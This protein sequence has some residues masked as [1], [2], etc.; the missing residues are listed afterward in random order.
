MKPI[1]EH[2]LFI[3]LIQVFFLLV[4][5]RTLG[6]IFRNFRQPPVIG[7]LLA[8]ILLGPTVLGNISPDIFLWL[9]PSATPQPQMLEIIAWLG[10]LLLLL[11]AGMEIDISVVRRQGRLAI[12]TSIM[13]IIV[14]FISGVILG[15][16]IP[17]SYLIDPDQRLLFSLFLGT[18]MSISA[19]PVIARI[20]MDLDLIKT[21]LGM[22][23]I[24]AALSNDLVGWIIFSIVLG[25]M[26]G[27]GASLTGLAEIAS[28]TLGFALFCF[29]LGR[30][31]IDK[32]LNWAQ[33]I[34]PWPTGVLTLALGVTLL[35]SAITQWIG[36][37]AIFGAFLAGV[38]IGD[39]PHLR[40]RTRET[41]SEFTA[42]VFAPIFFATV[43]LKVNLLQSFN[44]V[45]VLVLFAVAC[46]GKLVGCNLGARWGG[47]AKEDALC[48]SIAMNVRGAM[49]IILAI[50]AFK[51]GLIGD[52]IFVA[53]L[54]IAVIT[55]L[56]AAPLMK[57]SM[58]KRIIPDILSFFPSNSILHELRATNRDGTIQELID[59][60]MDGS[61]LA[62]TKEEVIKAVIQRE[63][64]MGTG[65]GRGVAFPHARL[66]GL[67][68]PLLAF[69][70]SR[71]GVDFNA[72]DG[73]LVHLIFLILT[74]TEDKGVQLKTLP[75]IARAMESPTNRER[76]MAVKN[77]SEFRV[78]LSE[79]LKGGQS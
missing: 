26:S 77:F 70:R 57:W 63:E 9:F 53:L 48:V 59:R 37:H 22:I 47:M 43:G 2:E 33:I 17:Q 24:A 41:I 36:I 56:I 50:L 25:L 14:P 79:Q 35:C 29:T 55:T 11:V 69:G 30:W 34:L 19:L 62:L 31:V 66:A 64:S 74:P 78:A 3:F 1:G 49:E 18:A 65:V 12:S 38:M 39:S 45:L 5:A 58:E 52:E 76:L 73:Q 71:L 28:L 42:S 21:D 40:E 8:G 44:P 46:L 60:V 13:G 6:E 51:Y 61:K 75:A 68:K 4:T 54:V 23:T 72:S 20:L 67:D 7:E 32:I 15:L 10:V 16:I 27:V